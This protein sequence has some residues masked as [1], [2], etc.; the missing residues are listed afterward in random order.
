[1]AKL[2]SFTKACGKNKP[3]GTKLK[4]YVTY[5]GELSG[6][7]Q[8]REAV[9]LAASGSPIAGD[10]KI[11]DEPWDFST[12]PTGEGFWRSFPILINTGQFRNFEEGEEGGKTMMNEIVGFI[13]DNGP[14]AREFVD[15]LRAGNG[16][17]IGMIPDKQGNHHVCGDI[18]NPCYVDVEEGGTGGDRVG[19]SIRLYSDSG[20]TNMQYDAD[21][22]GIDITPNP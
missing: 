16:C 22:H 10:T 21:T 17:I 4:C 9:V 6:M 3:K 5:T 2:T 8:T 13:D 14:A 19:Y 18:E 7:P 1:M 20:F 11:Y 12:A 15:C